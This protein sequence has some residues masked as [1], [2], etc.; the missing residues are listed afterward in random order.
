MPDTAS[1]AL[2][3][4]GFFDLSTRLEAGFNF[5]VD[6]AVDFAVELKHCLWLKHDLKRAHHRAPSKP[7]PKRIGRFKRLKLANF[8]AN[9]LFA[10]ETEQSVDL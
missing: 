9:I 10:L 8:L 5:A 7:F 2:V 4:F 1:S 6:F 3:T